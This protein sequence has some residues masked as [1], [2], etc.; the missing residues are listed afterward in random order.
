MAFKNL[1]SPFSGGLDSALVLALTKL[2]LRSGQDIAALYMPSRYSSPQ[3]TQLA[4][5]MSRDLGVPLHTLPIEQLH[6]ASR[7]IFASATHTPLTG[8]AD[9]NVQART[10][11]L[12]L[13][14]YSNQ[15]GGLV[16]NTSNKSELAVGYSTL[17][18]DSVGALSPL[19]DLY[20]SEAYQIARRINERFG[21]LIPRGIIDRPPSAELSSGQR[22]S[23]SLPDYPVLDAILEGLLSYGMS[24]RDLI[25]LGH[26]REDVERI[27][28]LYHNSEY[29][30]AQF[31]PI[32]KLK[33]KSFGSG[34][35]VPVSKHP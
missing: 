25:G 33:I 34:Y 18:G 19:G 17:Y 24:A 1:S 27:F 5:Q 4:Q 16:L 23:D 26:R 32:I 31:A 22:D 29:K 9:E 15:N 2:A 21:E 13:F 20:K 35:R 8:V 12:L 10:R 6:V 7:E 14:A 28:R 30:R 11:S 3:S